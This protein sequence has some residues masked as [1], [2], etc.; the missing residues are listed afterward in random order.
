MRKRLLKDY[1]S[2]TIRE[3]VGAARPTP[4]YRSV[5]FSTR[6]LRLNLK[7]LQLILHCS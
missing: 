1:F 7:M 5:Y 4:D 3:T 6:F 2:F